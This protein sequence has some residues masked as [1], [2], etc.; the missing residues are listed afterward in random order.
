MVVPELTVTP[1]SAD[2]ILGNSVTFAALANVTGATYSWQHMTAGGG[3]H[4]Y[5]RPHV[6]LCGCRGPSAGA[7][8][9]LPPPAAGR[10][11]GTNTF[12]PVRSAAGR[13]ASGVFNAVV[14][15]NPWEDVPNVQLTG[16]GIGP[17]SLA[18][19]GVL[20]Q[21]LLTQTQTVSSNGGQQVALT[22]AAGLPAGVYYL[23]IGAG[24]TRQVVRKPP[25]LPALSFLLLL[26]EP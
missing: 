17:V 26:I 11:G 24:G 20:G 5:G 8:G 23:R 21:V 18:L 10:P 13:P 2:I 6:P 15:L 25:Y 19:C 14:F 22:G 9:A 1:A 12:S 3:R 16:L 4:G 7:V